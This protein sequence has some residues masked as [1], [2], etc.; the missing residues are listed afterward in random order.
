MRKQKESQDIVNQSS[1]Q[2]T[3]LTENRLY[4][5]WNRLTI[6]NRFIFG[7]VMQ[8][9]SN[10]EPFLRRLFPNKDIG[11]IQSG[12]AEKTI[13]STLFSHGVRLDVYLK[14]DKNAFFTVEMQVAEKDNLPKRSRYYEKYFVLS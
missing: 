14:N 12:E 6:Q 8:D 3:A 2:E 5:H 4:E 11:R 1:G 9:P 7:K 10:C 13:E